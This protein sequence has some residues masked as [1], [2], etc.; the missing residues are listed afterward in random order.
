MKSA[1][2]SIG[3]VMLVI[4]LA[5]FALLNAA[6]SLQQIPATDSSIFQY[7]GERIT[8]GALPYRDV[9]DH[10]PP[11]IF[12]LDALGLAL[13]GRWGIWAIELL[14]LSAAGL[15]G[16][17]LLRRPFGAVPAVLAVAALLLN[18]VYVHDGGNLTEEFA[19]PLQF[20][21][22][23]LLAQMEARKKAGWRPYAI[24]LVLGLASSLKQPLAGPGIAIGV[25]L[26]A[27]RLGRRSWRG[28]LDLLWIG[29]GAASVWAAWAVWF[30]LNGSLGALWD[31]A[32]AHN[33]AVT[34]ISTLD[35]LTA[36]ASAVAQLSGA[37]FFFLIGFL[38]WL[39]GLPYLLL[40]GERLLQALTNRWAGL[41]LAL[42]GLLIA[43][44]GLFRTGLQVYALRELSLYRLALL[45][46]GLAMAAAGLVY[47]TRRL[48]HPLQRA[49]RRHLPGSSS[50]AFLVLTLAA[51]DLPVEVWLSTLSGA[52]FKHYFMALLPSLT[53]LVGFFAYSLLSFTNPNARRWMPA[54]WLAVFA[55]ALL[56]PGAA[57]TAG[58]TRVSIDRQIS[59]TAAYIRANSAPGAPVFQ[60]GNVPM[61]YLASGRSAPSRYFHTNPLFLKG[62]IGLRQTSVF[63]V[64]LQTNPPALIVVA[65]SVGQPLPYEPDSSRCSSLQEPETLAALQAK[66]EF[67]G[68]ENQPTQIPEGMGAVYMW[69]CQNY[70][71]SGTVGPRQWS[72]LRYQPGR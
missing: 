10:K 43:A 18:L 14:S 27:E 4:L 59:E 57:A 5:F 48:D 13:G 17:A 36:L 20:G 32:F 68:V 12:Y 3:W 41:V 35:H 7:I 25:Y 26:L 47:F 55:L 37:S 9:Y 60:W 21:A 50:P 28:L 71:E 66:G 52:N 44:N 34:Q 42:L 62:F 51:I 63:L 45:G 15:A 72:V 31:A 70:V 30:A 64:D 67:E 29:L 61:L 49:L 53:I 8:S 39:A 19:L 54:V 58:K 33:F 65:P 38:A 23:L 40:H 2:I 1:R 69:I 24:G 22:F 46:L 6:P 11:L 16:L 56:L